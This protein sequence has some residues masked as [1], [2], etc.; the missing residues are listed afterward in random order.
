[1]NKKISTFMITILTVLLI[2][3]IILGI[4]LPN[5]PTYIDIEFT[6][7]EINAYPSQTVWLVAEVTPITLDLTSVD[8][9]SVHTNI[10]ISHDEKIWSSQDGNIVEIFL[11][12]NSTHLGLEIDVTL[13]I[14]IA[15][16]T[17]SKEVTISVI[18]WSGSFHTDAQA[19]LKCFTS[20]L[21]TSVEGYTLEENSSL[22]FMG[23]VPQILIV[24]HFLFRTNNWELELTRHVTISPN[25]WV[26]IYL[27]ARNSFSPQWAGEISSWLSGN[28]SIIEIQPPETIYR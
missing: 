27:R 10:P 22:S 1:M 18:D 15:D 17:T 20:Y 9:F 12:P 5:S 3:S 24:E 8:L 16:I 4:Y 6:H 2:A 28:Y 19:A 26:R 23:I 11:Y 25:D 13:T 21:V 14:V 7:D